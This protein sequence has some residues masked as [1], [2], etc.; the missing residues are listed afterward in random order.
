MCVLSKISYFAMG[1]ATLALLAG[2]SGSG[3]TAPPPGATVTQQSSSRFMSRAGSRL[4]PC[5]FGRPNRRAKANMWR[6]FVAP[7]G[8]IR[9][10]TGDTIAISDG[11]NN[12]VDIFNAQGQQTA[13]LT[14]F[15]DPFGLASDIKGDLYVADAGNNR[16]Q[17]Y[18]KGF[19]LP[20]TT[21][22]VPDAQPIGVDSFNNGAYVAV[23][24][25]LG[26]GVSNIMI[27]KGSTLVT[28]IVPANVEPYLCAF[29]A[30]GN[31]YVDA[32]GPNGGAAAVGEVANATSGGNTYTPLT[33]SNAF[34]SPGGVQVTTNGQITIGDANGSAIYTYNPPSNGS[35]GAPVRTTLLPTSG[36]VLAYAFT[37][38]MRDLYT[39]DAGLDVSNEY[40]YPAG[41]TPVSTIPFSGGTPYGVAIIPTQYPRVTK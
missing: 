30:T 5:S 6:P 38:N 22:S 9:N 15:S 35:L 19:M 14:G 31:L 40:A 18:A 17:V 21:I 25:E 3:T 2:C 39:A 28:E 37:K 34:E 7:P 26:C 20:P 23:T 29:D 27:F 36:V 10:S 33:T 11:E 16:I 1:S 32:Y 41:G 13:Q 8:T 24:G 4:P 12:V